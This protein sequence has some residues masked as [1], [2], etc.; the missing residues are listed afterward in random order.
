VWLAIPIDFAYSVQ[1]ELFPT[2]W[3]P[4]TKMQSRCGAVV[5]ELTNKCWSDVS[6]RLRDFE[7]ACAKSRSDGIDGGNFSKA[8][9]AAAFGTGE[10]IVELSTGNTAQRRGVFPYLLSRAFDGSGDLRDRHNPLGR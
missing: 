5:I 4:P 9:I 7:S 3:I 1:S 2:P 10:V 8:N 6:E